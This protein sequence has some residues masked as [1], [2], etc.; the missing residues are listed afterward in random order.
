[1]QIIYLYT[2]QFISKSSSH[3]HDFAVSFILFTPDNNHSLYNAKDRKPEYKT[4]RYASNQKSK[5]PNVVQYH[6]RMMHKKNSEP[7][8]HQTRSM[9]YF[10]EDAEETTDGL[11]ATVEGELTAA[12]LKMALVVMV[13]R[14]A[15]A[16]VLEDGL[17]PSNEEEACDETAG[18]EVDEAGRNVDCSMLAGVLENWGNRK[19]SY[20]QGPNL[21]AA[22]LFQS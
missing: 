9:G 20:A 5:M 18:D 21:T 6:H 1:M 14:G 13:G 8:L 7:K 17:Y 22:P 19:Y 15:I 12:A 3:Y 16:D 2:F 10:R 4:P 11:I